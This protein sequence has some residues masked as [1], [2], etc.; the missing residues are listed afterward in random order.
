M[1]LRRIRANEAVA[2]REIRLRA[3]KDSPRT[4]GSSYAEEVVRTPEAWA[5][6]TR[7]M[8]AGETI[9]MFV[10]EAAGGLVGMAGAY[11]DPDDGSLPHLISM[12]VAPEA[13]RGGVGRALVEMVVGWARDG[14]HPSIRLFVVAENETA[15]N[16]YRRCG[17]LPTG[18][19][20]PL[21]RDHTVIEE[22]M[23]QAL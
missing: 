4:F 10:A 6:S 13:R 9:V 1:Q 15:A 8:A 14:G 22:E 16:L 3:L 5:E 2:W 19:T 23:R 17:F 11:L 18:R 7:R 21:P 20:I 12:W